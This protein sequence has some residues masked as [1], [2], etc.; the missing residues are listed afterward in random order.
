MAAAVVLVGHLVVNSVDHVLEI[1]VDFP[2]AVDK[3]DNRA[4]LV[5]MADNQDQE[6]NGDDLTIHKI[7]MDLGKGNS[8]LNCCIFTIFFNDFMLF[9]AM[10]I[11]VVVLEVMETVL[12]NSHHIPHNSIHK[13]NRLVAKLAAEAM[14]DMVPVLMV[15]MMANIMRAVIPHRIQPVANMAMQTIPVVVMGRHRVQ[16]VM[17]PPATVVDNKVIIVKVVVT[18]I[19]VVDMRRPAT[20]CN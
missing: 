13:G 6:L 5:A 7:K 19:E 9:L 3:N 18:M 10:E 17:E 14:V 15:A 11:L 12:A 2:V 1:A 20:V 8:P 16:K 4:N